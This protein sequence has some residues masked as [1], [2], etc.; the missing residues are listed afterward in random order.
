ML[1]DFK[2]VVFESLARTGNFRRTASDL[3]VSQPTVSQII[4]D[5]EREIG[6]PLFIRGRNGSTLTA[7]GEAFLVF[8]TGITDS[9]EEMRLAMR[10]FDRL[11]AV[12]KIR[13][14]VCEERMADVCVKLLPYLRRAFPR[15]NVEMVSSPED[16]DLRYMPGLPASPSDA[17]AA[18]PLLP[19]I[20]RIVK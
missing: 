16:A 5:L 20:L 8:S 17:F 19:L 3:D 2:L 13:L 14:Y 4:A 15:M 9:Y 6:R 10:E 18:S 7:A 12:D 11:E 1:Q